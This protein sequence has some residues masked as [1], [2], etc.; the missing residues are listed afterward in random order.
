M[1]SWVGEPEASELPA[2]FEVDWFRHW[3]EPVD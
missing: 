3:A 1:Y 2:V